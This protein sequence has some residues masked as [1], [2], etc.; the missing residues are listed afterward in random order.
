MIQLDQILAILLM[1]FSVIGMFMIFY[2]LNRFIIALRKEGY[3]FS[4]RK[5]EKMIGFLVLLLIIGG[6]FFYISSTL[7]SV[8]M[9]ILLIGELL[10]I[11]SLVD[12]MKNKDTTFYEISE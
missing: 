3:S 4:I 7:S 12:G 5:Y 8:V 1:L 2:I 10:F 6:V 11:F 9:L